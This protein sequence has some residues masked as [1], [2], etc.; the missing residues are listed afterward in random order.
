MQPAHNLEPRAQQSPRGSSRAVL[1]FFFDA[2]T[3]PAGSASATVLAATLGAIACLHVFGVAWLLGRGEFWTYPHGDAASA[4]IGYRYFV[5]DAWHWP[6]LKTTA[7]HGPVGQNVLFL[8]VIPAIALPAK[9]IHPITGTFNPYGAWFLACYVLQA[10]FAVRFARALGG[11]SLFAAVIASTFALTSQV[12]L[13]RFYHPDLCAQFCIFWAFGLYFTHSFDAP[14][15]RVF[16]AWTAQLAIGLLVHPYLFAMSAPIFF[17]AALRAKVATPKKRV[18]IVASVLASLTALALATGHLSGDVLHGRT[19]AFGWAS[20]NLGSLVVPMPGRSNLCPHVP[21][22]LLE[23]TGVQWDGFMFLGFGVLVLALIHV[24]RSHREILSAIRAHTPLAVVLLLMLAYAPSNRVFLFRWLLV[25]Y[26]VPAF[27]QWPA[28]QFRAT[29][30]FAWPFGFFLIVSVVPFT[31]KRFR[32]R[33]AAP[34]LCACTLLELYDTGPSRSVARAETR[35]AWN[36]RL[37]WSAWRSAIQAH[38]RVEQ[39]P[40]YQCLDRIVDS[41][42]GLTS[43]EVQYLAAESHRPI[44]GVYAGR[45]TYD[46]SGEST[47]FD[48]R[49]PNALLLYPRAQAPLVRPPDCRAIDLWVVCTSRW[50]TPALASLEREIDRPRP[51]VY[52]QILDFGLAKTAIDYLDGGWGRADVDRMWVSERSRM[53]LSVLVDPSYLTHLMLELTNNDVSATLSVEVSGVRAATFVSNRT[54]DATF[55][56]ALPPALLPSE[57]TTIELLASSA[58]SFAIKKLWLR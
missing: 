55:E 57:T 23:A 18:A 29:G 4:V 11:N 3:A 38:E 16:R 44:N 21:P 20:H 35:R 50:S 15:S 9:L 22:R 34:L 49:D 46:C 26:D 32:F 17:A 28:N 6:L 13:L 31:L 41:G 43:R 52:G 51:Y 33:F 30:R 54:G 7:I 42:V 19:G 25:E 39:R 47:G 27:L 5:E 40:S 24:V 36:Q 2:I 14:A 45:E 58:G 1:A 53:R 8:D 12:F 37:D 10:V 48:N 56:V